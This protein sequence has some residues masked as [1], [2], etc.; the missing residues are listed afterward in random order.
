MAK[1]MDI[2]HST[3]GRRGF[4]QSAGGV[5]AGLAL[6]AAGPLFA[7]SSRPNVLLILVDQMRQAKWTPELKTP[8]VDR[9]AGKGVSFVNHFVS[10]S[11]CSPSRSCLLT[12]TYTTQN[13]MFTNCDFVEGERQPSLDPRIPTFGHVFGQAGY[14]TPYRGKWHLTRKSDLNPNDPLGDYGFTGWK[15]PDAPFGGSAYN[16]AIMDPIYSRQACRWLL[17]ADNHRQPWFLVCSL[18]NPHDICEY[19]LYYPQRKLRPIKTDAPPPNWTDDLS[20]K[21]GAQREFQKNYE[22]FA[23]KVKL[24]DPDA[25]RRYLDYYIHCME[26]V[27]RNLGR[28]LEAL[29]H[30]GQAGNTIIVFTADHGEMGGS[31]QLRTKGSFAYEEEMNVPLIFTCPGHL[32]EG[33]TVNSFAASVDVM[34]T[35]IELA[36]IRNSNYMAG[37][38]LASLL[39]DPKAAGVR[40]EVVFHQDWEM[41]VKIGK[42][43]DAPTMRHPAHIRCLRGRDWKYAHY[44]SPYNDG[45]EY[46]LYDLKNDPLEMVNLASDA[47]YQAR[48]KEMHERLMERENKLVEEFKPFAGS[49]P[50]RNADVIK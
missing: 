20:G 25:W 5:A 45:V 48:K 33:V 23:G 47:G 19:P 14:Q 30:S 44:F 42:S 8:N 22:S 15:P 6:G 43:P 21:P 38:S 35:L 28:V 49:G 10:A 31:H 40:E 46:E 36:G 12:G 1:M 9:L 27:D 32:P 18:V 7:G 2:P 41:A 29:E 3:I 26:E 34:P 17:D 50:G 11:P 13:R 39:A 37:V 4:I 16:G 24:S